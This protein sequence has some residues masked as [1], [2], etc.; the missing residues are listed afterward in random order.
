MN[1][2]PFTPEIYVNS[3]NVHQR[4][5]N[6]YKCSIFKSA[7]QI[8]AHDVTIQWQLNVQHIVEISQK[9]PYRAMIE[10]SIRKAFVFAVALQMRTAN[11]MI[12]IDTHRLRCV[13]D[14]P[15]ENGLKTMRQTI[16]KCHYNCIC[17]EYREKRQR[18]RFS[19]QLMWQKNNKWLLL[20]LLLLLLVAS[21]RLC[22]CKYGCVCVYVKWMQD[23]KHTSDVNNNSYI[24]YKQHINSPDSIEN[25]TTTTN[26]PTDNFS[27]RIL[28]LRCFTAPSSASSRHCLSLFLYV[29]NFILI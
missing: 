9:Y 29:Y 2:T 8:N 11:N 5:W 27:L 24:T 6:I 1:A 28:L 22:V 12:G 15:Y 10:S 7:I 21:C 4:K 25:T 14:V 23:S 13:F 3:V 16:L 20:L 18:W 17:S 19:K 26:Q